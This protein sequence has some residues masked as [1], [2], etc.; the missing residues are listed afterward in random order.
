MTDTRVRV[1]FDSV[2]TGWNPGDSGAFTPAEAKQFV[3]EGVAHYEEP[4]KVTHKPAAKKSPA[5]SKRTK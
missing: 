1:V 5:R 2:I 4:V 3:D